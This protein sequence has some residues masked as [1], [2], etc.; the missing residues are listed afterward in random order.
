MRSIMDFQTARRVGRT[1]STRNPGRAASRTR[2]PCPPVI[3]EPPARE[4]SPNGQPIRL[5]SVPAAEPYVDAVRP[6]G[7]IGV[8]SVGAAGFWPDAAWLVENAAGVDVLHVHAGRVTL[9][10]EPLACWAETLRRLDIPLVVTVHQLRD[11]ASP[12]SGAHEAAL[13]V[14]LAT[15]EV[16]FTLTPGA[17][18]EIADR[19]GRTAIVVAH[20]SVVAP[21]PEG[22][23]GPG[24][25]G[26]G[27]PLGR[28]IGRGPATGSR[29]R[30]GRAGARPGSAR[31]C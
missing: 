25:A 13:D 12:L 29:L 18:D 3:V 16:V 11:P 26:A 31:A 19:Y 28:G 23:A 9:P 4:Q 17:A 30:R 5:V 6:A 24:P 14:L 10:A 27:R 20:P 22:G 2:S 8:P 7:A 1:G 15:A 21:H